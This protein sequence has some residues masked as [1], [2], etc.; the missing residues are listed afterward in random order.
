M[1]IWTEGGCRVAGVRVG[2][3][4]A[5]VGAVTSPLPATT[6]G[7]GGDDLASAGRGFSGA[8]A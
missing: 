5:G 6:A 3:A 1:G 7:G 8:T 2:G 4:G